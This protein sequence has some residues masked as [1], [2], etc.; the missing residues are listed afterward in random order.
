MKGLLGGMA[1][2]LLIPAWCFAQNG[3]LEQASCTT[4]SG[5]ANLPGGNPPN[6]VTVG[7]Y[8]YGSNAVWT[9]I[10][11]AVANLYRS[12]IQAEINP[13]GNGLYGFSFATPASLIDGTNH[14][15]R[16]QIVGGPVLAYSGSGAAYVN[17]TSQTPYY[18][19][20]EAVSTNPGPSDSGNWTGNGSIG[21]GY[22]GGSYIWNQTPSG[23]SSQYEV[24]T[25]I[26]LTT[27][28][29]IYQHYL[30]AQSNALSGAGGNTFL[31]ELQNPSVTGAGGVPRTWQCTRL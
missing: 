11:T 4:I 16:I 5:W 8:E 27:S 12:D 26:S 24:R 19:Y 30:R 31:V 14:P 15:V 21:S 10:G 2:L 29:G 28:G 20:T 13:S 7:L 1:F 3:Y 22:P 18:S 23:W 25:N 17:C 9:E 6:P